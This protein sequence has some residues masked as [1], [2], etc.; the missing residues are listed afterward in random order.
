MPDAHELRMEPRAGLQ[1]AL[2]LV[3]AL[4]SVL[5]HMSEREAEAIAVPKNGSPKTPRRPTGN[6]SSRP[7]IVPGALLNLKIDAEEEYDVDE[8]AKRLAVS[9][10][11]VRKMINHD[12]LKAERRGEGRGHWIIQGTELLRFTHQT[13][14]QL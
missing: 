4:L 10:Q 7:T 14:D 11:T 12:K 2:N 6:G 8:V 3:T 1:L 5:S 13:D 9:P